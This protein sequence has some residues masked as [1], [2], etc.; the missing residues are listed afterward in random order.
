[1]PYELSLEPDRDRGG[2]RY[3]IDMSGDVTPTVVR[4]LSDWLANATQNPAA[5]FEINLTTG[6]RTTPRARLELASLMRRH[7]RLVKER[8]LFVLTP[9]RARRRLPGAAGARGAVFG[10]VVAEGSLGAFPF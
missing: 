1:M 10:S 2:S 9:K 8:R 4:Q 5:S 3:R 6:V 7:R